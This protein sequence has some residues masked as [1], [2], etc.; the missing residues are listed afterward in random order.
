MIN[1]IDLPK[2]QNRRSRHARRLPSSRSGQ[3]PAAPPIMTGYELHQSKYLR[4]R[5]R[6]DIDH[7]RWQ[8]KD[9]DRDLPE[10]TLIF[11]APVQVEKGQYP[12]DQRTGLTTGSQTHF[13]QTPSAKPP[14]SPRLTLPY[15][16]PAQAQKHVT[17]NQ[18]IRQN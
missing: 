1:L 4:P 2:D 3:H 7:R 10:C 18:A 11:A 13:A 15:I 17:H 5:R 6:K 8:S 16:Q 9:Y 12:L 14:Q